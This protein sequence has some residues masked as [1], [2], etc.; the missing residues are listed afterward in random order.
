MAGE[1]RAEGLVETTKRVFLTTNIMFV[2]SSHFLGLRGLTIPEN[3]GNTVDG[4]YPGPK[5]PAHRE[6]E[7][8]VIMAHERATL[9]R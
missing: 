1:N 2:V 6:S 7:L 5:T 9:A 3:D 4:V 8:P